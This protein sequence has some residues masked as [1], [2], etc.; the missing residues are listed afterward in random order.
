VTR[1][2]VLG[3][4][5]APDARLPVTAALSSEGVVRIVEGVRLYRALGLQQLVVSGGS[6]LSVDASAR[7]YAELARDLGVSPDS[8]IVLDQPNDTA[9][10]AKA[11]RERL[12][13]APFVLVTSASHMPRAMRL[14]TANGLHAFPAPTAHRVKA[15]EYSKLQQWVPDGASLNA[16]EIALHEYLGLLALSVGVK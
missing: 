3:S 1:L 8:M 9:Q 14:M 6:A 7:G 10:E 15:G 2:V 5:Y 4:S 11:I 16:T 12:G 13:D